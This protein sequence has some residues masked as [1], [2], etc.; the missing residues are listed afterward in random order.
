MSNYKNRYPIPLASLDA[1]ETAQMGPLPGT[2][3]APA[4]GYVRGFF[5]GLMPLEFTGT[6]DETLAWHETCTL[7]T[8]L[9]PTP[10]VRVKGPGAIDFMRDN[11]PNNVDNWPIGA[12]KHGLM[13]LEDGTIAAQ[14][15]VIRIDEDEYEGDWLSPFFEYRFSQK[16]YDAE[17]V[18]LTFDMFMFQLQG[19][20][21][22]AIV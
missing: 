16:E 7:C 1:S 4:K 13:L 21:S 5:G 19:P 20:E 2:P 12:S 8:V 18:D 22:L 10:R 9:N 17:L 6:R 3:L 11:F 14:G 15:V